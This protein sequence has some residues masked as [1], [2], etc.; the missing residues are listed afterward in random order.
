[1]GKKAQITLFI[2]VAILLVVGAS[3]VLF[4]SKQQ[5]PQNPL[6]DVKKEA[7]NIARSDS[8]RVYVETCLEQATK[9]AVDL[10]GRQGGFVYDS[11][12]GGGIYFLGPGSI[13]CDRFN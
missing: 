2:L 13:W 11:Q 6:D 12:V 10:V 4:F 1:M 5:A 7:E 9:D 8:L 3:Y